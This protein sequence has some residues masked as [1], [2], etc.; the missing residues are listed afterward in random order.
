M[1]AEVFVDRSQRH[2][3]RALPGRLTIRRQA[4]TIHCAD[5]EFTSRRAFMI[6]SNRD[7]PLRL[8]ERAKVLKVNLLQ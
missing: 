3:L 7:L 1:I 6:L 4:R 2:A 8:S 5:V